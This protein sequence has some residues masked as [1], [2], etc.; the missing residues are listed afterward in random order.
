M[1]KRNKTK[2]AVALGYDIE[3]DAAPRVYA[4]GGGDVAKKIIET[5]LKYGIPIKKDPALV[6]VLSLLD[7]G[8][9]IPENVY[10]A[11]AE[12]LAFVYSLERSM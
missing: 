11:V 1:K 2:K 10:K 9:E 6:E 4:S 5:A 3:K 12:I 7:I 8:E